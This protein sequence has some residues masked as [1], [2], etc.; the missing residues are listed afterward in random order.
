MSGEAQT[1]AGATIDVATGV[2]ATNDNPGFAALSY[3]N[4]GEVTNVS[5]FGKVFNEVTHN[6]LASRQTCKLKGSYDNGTVT[7]D[8]AQVDT[9]AGQII[10][11][12]AVDSDDNYS[13]RLTKQDG[14]IR[15]FIARVMSNPE[16]PGGVDDIYSGTADLSINNDVV[17]VAAP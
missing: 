17:K 11:D 4:I 9:D 10:L 1:S 13:F 16:N 3:S 6:P 15:Y 12:A 8:Y 5:S 2:P 14:A 7:I